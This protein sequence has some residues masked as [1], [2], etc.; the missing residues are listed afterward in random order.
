MK[1]SCVLSYIRHH[2]R[3]TAK[4]GTDH[5]SPPLDCKLALKLLLAVHGDHLLYTGVTSYPELDVQT[6]R[7]I[8]HPLN[9]IIYGLYKCS[10]FNK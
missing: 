4:D 2:L 5:F 1:C 10:H 7:A 3:R 9:L 6:D 8:I